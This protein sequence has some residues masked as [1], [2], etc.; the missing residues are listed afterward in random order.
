M[1]AIGR[2][3]WAIPEGYIPSESKFSDRACPTRPH[4]SSMPAITM[5]GSRSP[6]ILRIASRS[7]PTKSPSARAGPCICASTT[8][9]IPSRYRATPT[10]PLYSSPTCPSSSSTPG[11]IPV[12]PNSRCCRRW[13]MRKADRQAFFRFR[14]ANHVGCDFTMELSCATAIGH[15]RPP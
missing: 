14:V 11:W 6:F 9:T 5:R 3:R 7:D 12:A 10:M 4:A 2:R 1:N 8:S 15:R 13:H